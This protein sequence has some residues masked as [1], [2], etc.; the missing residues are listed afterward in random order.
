MSQQTREIGIRLPNDLY[1]RMLRVK[2]E[3]KGN[4]VGIDN[5]TISGIIRYCIMNQLPELEKILKKG[6]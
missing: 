5:P 2:D 3:Y 4:S 6:E 1:D